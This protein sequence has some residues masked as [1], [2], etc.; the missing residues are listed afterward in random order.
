MLTLESCD[1]LHRKWSLL[2]SYRCKKWINRK[3]CN[4][5][6]HFRPYGFTYPEEIRKLIYTTNAIEGF[7]RQLRKVTKTRTVFPTDDSLFKILFLAMKDITAKWYGKPHNWG[8]IISQLMISFPDRISDEDF[9]W[10]QE[11]YRLGW[12][13]LPTVFVDSTFICI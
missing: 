12:K 6:V 4:D 7:N 11:L 10:F 3:N 5:N 8:L 2:G 1:C 9:I 13:E